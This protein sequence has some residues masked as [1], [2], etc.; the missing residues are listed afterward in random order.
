VYITLLYIII[1]IIIIIIGIITMSNSS[2]ILVAVTKCTVELPLKV[3][4]DVIL[5]LLQVVPIRERAAAV[6]SRTVVTQ[7]YRQPTDSADF[8]SLPGMCSCLRFV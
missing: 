2:T 7:T 5:M 6:P 1:V 3:V 8:S 4:D